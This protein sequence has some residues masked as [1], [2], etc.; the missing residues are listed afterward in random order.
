MPET[1]DDGDLFQESNDGLVHGELA[2]LELLPSKEK[3]G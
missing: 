1:Y 2:V 3:D